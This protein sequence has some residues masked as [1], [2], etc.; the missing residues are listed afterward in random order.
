MRTGAT[1]IAQD[2]ELQDNQ[3]S[4][5]FVTGATSLL[6]AK[7]VEVAATQPAKP[8]KDLGIGVQVTAGAKALLEDVRIT[9]GH[10]AG[11]E[12]E[13]AGSQ[14]VAS[15]P[16]ID[17]VAAD[18][19]GKSIGAAV[20]AFHGA[21]VHVAHARFSAVTTTAVIALNPNTLVRLYDVAI[22]GTLPQPVTHD[23]G[24]GI[25]AQLGA[26]LQLAAVRVAGC[27]G[28]GVIAH[29]EGTQLS[30]F[31]L[32]VEGSEVRMSDGGGGHGVYVADGAKA[33]LEAA[34][35]VHNRSTGLA[36]DHAALIADRCVVRDTTYAPLVLP[37][38]KLG[39]QLA[40]GLVAA[41][42]TALSVQRSL[43]AN[44][45]R[46]AVLIDATLAATLARTVVS[47]GLYGV[48][49]QHGSS[50]QSLNNAVFGASLQ[51]RAGDAGLAVP[52]APKLVGQ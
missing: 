16:V 23:F 11:L 30:A 7:R 12:V 24:V 33:Y 48:V 18:V 14:A 52:A 26:E 29:G 45:A 13:G 46:A 35:I 28:A 10:E 19:F 39:Q 47:G 6:Q 15:R 20:Y 36:A 17:Q 38:L 44:N 34:L 2:M 27:R 3:E 42:A 50:V 31:G 43:F 1:V 22:D 8:Q 37:D 40:D 4:A 41:A 5:L 51:N 9:G 25:A 21:V 32:V 49:T